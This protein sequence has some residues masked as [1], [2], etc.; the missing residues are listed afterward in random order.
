MEGS[1]DLSDEGYVKLSVGG[2]S[3]DIKGENFIMIMEGVTMM[4]EIHFRVKRFALVSKDISQSSGQ[5]TVSSVFYFSL[6]MSK[7]KRSYSYE[8]GVSRTNL[9]YEGRRILDDDTPSILEMIL[10]S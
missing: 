4:R 2:N 1:N 10:L 8:L 7:L 5:W 6:Q 9:R 3:Q